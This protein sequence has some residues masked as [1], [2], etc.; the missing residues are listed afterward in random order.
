MFRYCHVGV[1]PI[2]NSYDADVEHHSEHR[3][4][5]PKFSFAPVLREHSN[6][7]QGEG[8]MRGSGDRA[9]I[10]VN[11]LLRRDL[12]DPLARF[13]LF[14]VA[15]LTFRQPLVYPQRR[16]MECLDQSPHGGAVHHQFHCLPFPDLHHSLEYPR[17]VENLRQRRGRHN[18]WNPAEAESLLVLNLAHVIDAVGHELQRVD[19]KFVEA[20]AGR[21]PILRQ[22]QLPQ[23]LR[24]HRMLL[25]HLL[26]PES[27][28]L[29]IVL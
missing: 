20:V 16:G 14:L 24:L 25:P 18:L 19:H 28:A 15:R 6:R 17:I 12:Q 10:R 9:D 22:G 5:E 13:L 27:P 29:H 2:T 23:Q 21:P 26:R 7:Q 4:V 1:H 3:L 11:E 8:N